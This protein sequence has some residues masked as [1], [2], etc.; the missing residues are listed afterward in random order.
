MTAKK[1]RLVSIG[2]AGKGGLTYLGAGIVG[3]AAALEFLGPG[4]QE[5]S[6]LCL[7]LGIAMGIAGIRRNMPDKS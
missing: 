1:S 7:E 6:K 3:L 4:Y 5:F 2:M